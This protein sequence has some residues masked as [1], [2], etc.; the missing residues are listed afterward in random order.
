MFI[1]ECLYLKARCADQYFIETPIT[2]LVNT[3]Y[4]MISFYI[5]NASAYKLKLMK[6][7][8][9]MFKLKQSLTGNTKHNF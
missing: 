5:F 8:T 1:L 7:S 4:V 2:I 6:T 9:K 3:A